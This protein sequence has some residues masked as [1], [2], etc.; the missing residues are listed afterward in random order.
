MSP[1]YKNLSEMKKMSNE[2]KSNAHSFGQNCYHLIWSPKYRIPM[3]KPWRINKV[4]DGVLRMIA[5]QNGMF[6]H[7]MQVM[8]DHIHCFV[9][10]PPTLSVS[11][12]LQILK[13]KSSRILRRNFRFL[14]KFDHLWS[15]GKFYRSVG[16][17]TKEVVQ[18]YI[19]KSQGN[20]DYFDTRRLLYK[21]EQTT[22][23]SL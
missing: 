9:E 5:T 21:P 7:E 14:R 19:A 2:L 12:A 16:S 15:Q 6:I 10:I 8:P 11:K 20:Y 4:C 1:I 23:T 17:V 13:G 18:H 3:L 22:L